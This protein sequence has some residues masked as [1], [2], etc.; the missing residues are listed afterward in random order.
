MQSPHFENEGQDYHR[1]DVKKS[2]LPEFDADNVTNLRIYYY[3]ASPTWR[4]YC[5]KNLTFYAQGALKSQPIVSVPSHLLSSSMDEHQ[6]NSLNDILKCAHTINAY[7][8]NLTM[9]QKNQLPVSAEDRNISADAK[10]Q[11]TNIIVSLK[12][13]PRK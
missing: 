9:F 8:T 10:I 6:T 7:K 2:F 5:L 12:Y 13:D 4:N 1:I 11:Q 3:Q